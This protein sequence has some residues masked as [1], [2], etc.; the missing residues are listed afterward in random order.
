MDSEDKR[1]W[2]MEHALDFW[3]RQGLSDPLLINHLA[4]GIVRFLEH[5]IMDKTKVPA[6]VEEPKIW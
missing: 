5:G 6:A 3:A 2:A 1:M 4:C